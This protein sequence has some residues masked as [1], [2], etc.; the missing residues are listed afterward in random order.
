MKKFFVALL[1]GIGYLALYLGIQILVV[2]VYQFVKGFVLGM[3]YAAQGMDLMDPEVMN[4]Y[5]EE[6]LQAV[7]DDSAAITVVCNIL[8]V[9][10]VALIIVCRKRKITK[11]LSLRKFSAKAV[12]PLVVLGIG[13]NLLTSVGLGMLPEDIL[14]AYAE[15]SAMLTEGVDFWTIA[16]TVVMAPLAEEVLMRGLVYTRMKKGMPMLV[17]M[18]LSSALFGVLHGQWVWMIYAALLGMLLVWIFERT[19]SL[20]ACIL[21]PFC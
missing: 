17:A 4:L 10:V 20:C 16:L 7:T 21:F 15:A 19:Q 2:N 9:A 6:I 18:I 13:L 8:L 1:K 12:L 3:K 14:E 11:E 5:M